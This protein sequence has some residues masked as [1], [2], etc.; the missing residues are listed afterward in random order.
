MFS[1]TGSTP[2]LSDSLRFYA[3]D[4]NVPVAD[5]RRLMLQA[6]DAL[7]GW[8]KR[9]DGV[10]WVSAEELEACRKRSCAQEGGPII[11]GGGRGSFL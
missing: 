5:L 4:G 3:K 6:A 10:R 8:E 2:T 9:W 11:G 1:G 7:E